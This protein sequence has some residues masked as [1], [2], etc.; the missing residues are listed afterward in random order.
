LALT[1]TN[2]KTRVLALVEDPNQDIYTD[3]TELNNAVNDAKDQVFSLVRIFTDEYPQANANIAFAAT[4]TEKA[5]PTDFL[6]ILRA[7]SIVSGSTT[8]KKHRIIDFR[9]QDFSEQLVDTQDLWIRRKSDGTQVLGRKYPGATLTV[10]IYYVPDVSD[11]SS[12]SATYNFGPPPIDN[13]IILKSVIYLLLS[14]GRK[15][16]ARSYMA[17]EQKLEGQ[18][19]ENLKMMD[20]SDTRYVNYQEI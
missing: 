9:Q 19:Q 13:L 15:E 6:E 16:S 8:S 18:L 20:K 7:E 5:L 17:R 4:D 3:S 14:R 10:T 12:S 2:I 1:F 11:I